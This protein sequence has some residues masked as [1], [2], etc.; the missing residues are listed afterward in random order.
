M[1]SSFKPNTT[2]HHSIPLDFKNVQK[3][4]A[5]HAWNGPATHEDDLPISDVALMVPVIDLEDPC[6]G[7]LIR[8]ACE[9]WGVF[10]VV[11][12]GI[13]FDL[14]DQAE[15][16]TMKLFSLPADRKTLAA[17]LPDVPTGYGLPIMSPFFRKLMWFEGFIVSGS[18]MEHAMKLW[19]NHVEDR[20]KFCNVL[21]EYQKEMKALA[22]KLFGIMASSLGL[23]IEKE[24]E[25]FRDG[26]HHARLNMNY[27]PPCPDPTQAVGLAAHTDS[28][29]ITLVYPS[30]TAN[31]YRGLQVV[32]EDNSNW[33][34]VETMEGA[35]FVNLGDLMK[36]FTNGR[37]KNVMHRV[38]VHKSRSRTSRAYFYGPP[39]EVKISPAVKLLDDGLSAM[40]HPV[41]WDDVLKE[42]AKCFNKTL[43]SFKI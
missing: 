9:K 14:L 6:V 32:S 10:Q 30:T 11:N 17:R 34:T 40:Y 38:V 22:E 29:L 8:S 37:F 35:I 24:L 13:S 27:Y 33:A 31:T 42:K 12:H 5:S 16:Q 23:N 21:V 18:P 1:D 26:Q 39:P 15:K 41:S 36:V 20:T 7:E 3:V 43:D 4:P 2:T 28:S 19:P 25:W